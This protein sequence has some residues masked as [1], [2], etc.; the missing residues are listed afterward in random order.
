MLDLFKWTKMP[1]EPGG[2]EVMSK[3]R[4]CSICSILLA[5]ICKPQPE[6]S[7]DKEIVSTVVPYLLALHFKNNECFPFPP[8]YKFRVSEE[9]GN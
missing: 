2:D 7:F 9:E 1:A 5:L 6:A 8:S 3:K 4:N